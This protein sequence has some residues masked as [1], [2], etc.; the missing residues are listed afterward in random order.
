MRARTTVVNLRVKADEK[1]AWQ[2]MAKDEGVTLADLI[3]TR[4]ST[5]TVDRDP[6]KRRAGRK[7]DP[8]LLANIGRVGSNLNQISR[9]ANTY[10]SAAE[11]S[12]ILLALVAIEQSLLTHTPSSIKKKKEVGDVS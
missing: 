1:E 8:L 6:I 11:A 10:K 7:A 3:R 4:L 2:A 9:W 5:K 12:E